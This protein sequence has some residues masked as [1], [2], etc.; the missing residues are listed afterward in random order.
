MRVPLSNSNFQF[1]Q[2]L[3]KVAEIFDKVKSH[4]KLDPVARISYPSTMRHYA[5]K[6]T[7]TIEKIESI[8]LKTF[9]PVRSDH[10]AP[11]TTAQSGNSSGNFQ[12]TK[13]NSVYKT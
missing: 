3:H 11:G 8:V 12:I 6:T 1:S 4:N 9:P 5:L 7:N 13:Y 10:V 2:S